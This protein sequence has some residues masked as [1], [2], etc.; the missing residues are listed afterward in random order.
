VRIERN[1]E[2][3]TEARDYKQCGKFSRFDPGTRRCIYLGR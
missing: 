1:R 3:G 2:Q